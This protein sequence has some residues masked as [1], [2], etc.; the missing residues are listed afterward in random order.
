MK[1]NN[2]KLDRY[3]ALAGAFLGTAAAA[4][5]AIVYTDVD[6]DVVVSN[7]DFLIDMDSDGITDFRISQYGYSSSSYGYVYGSN[8]AALYGNSSANYGFVAPAGGFS[9]LL[10]DA[11]PAG[12][13]IGSSSPITT[14][15]FATI[16][17]ASL[18]SSFSYA[19]GVWAGETDKYMGVSFEIAGATHYGWIRCDAASN[20]STVTVKGFA[21][22]DVAGVAIAAGDEGTGTACSTAIPPQ[23]PTHVDGTSAATLSWDPVSG[24]VACQVKGTRLV[25][26][27]PSPSINLFG[28]EPTT[29][30][31]PYAA[32]GAGSTWEWSV[33][34]ACSTSPIASTGF[35]ETDTFNVP[36]PG[37]MA[38]EVLAEAFPNPA[39]G[40]TSIQLNEGLP[41]ITEIRVMDL[42]G[43]VVDWLQ[44]PAEVRNVQLDVA[45]LE[46]GVY[47]VQVGH[48]DAITIEVAH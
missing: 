18:S 45:H 21:Y 9:S 20:Y 43:R 44:L 36:G 28:A 48:M 30:N 38:A 22:E 11:L 3:A 35:S 13:S 24:S 4:D 8:F 2:F 31:V 27:G 33:R 7:A 16:G 6:P 32:A 15:T 1:K 14:N 47:F 46:S 42:S 5:A 10:V 17:A 12:A 25:P 37:K 39:D 23:N 34:C 26:P 29:I 19:Y 41:H 40:F